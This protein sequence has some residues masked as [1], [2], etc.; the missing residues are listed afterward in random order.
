MR[1]IKEPDMSLSLTVLGKRLRE[2]RINSGLTQEAAAQ[3]IA[4]TRTALVQIEA[5]N[6]SVNTFE[7]VELAKL[8]RADISL[9]LSE[10]GIE[11]DDPLVALCRIEPHLSD[12]PVVESQIRNHVDIFREGVRLEQLL[13]EDPRS[14]PPVY[15]FPE[16]KSYTEAVRQGQELATQERKRLNL[17]FAPLTN[18]ATL[19]TAQGI[20]AAAT[21]LSDDLSGL[22]LHHPALGMAILIN[23]AHTRGRRRFSYCHEYAHALADRKRAATVT[24]RRNSNELIEKRANAFAIEFLMPTG[25]VESALERLNRGGLSRQT[26]WLYDVA[27]DDVFHGEKRVR[28]SSRKILSQDVALLAYEFQ[29]SYQAAAYKLSDLRYVSRQ[30]LSELLAQKE[31]GKAFLQV[32]RLKDPEGFNEEDEEQTN[33]T[34]QIGRLIIEAYRRK[35]ITQE[36]AIAVCRKLKISGEELLTFAQIDR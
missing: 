4:V 22:F 21:N 5:G 1:E 11:N 24:S 17:G 9:L 8:Y 34:G 6:R 16:P 18:V 27:N 35:L 7:L 31:N 26:V 12:N 19:I 23:N 20:W 36:E 30:E 3:K 33:L 32:L 28:A 2:A 10:H 14:T 29:V 13:E 25:G 15:D